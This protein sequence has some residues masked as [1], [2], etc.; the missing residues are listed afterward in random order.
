MKQQNSCFESKALA[1]TILEEVV[2]AIRFMS[3][4]RY[5]ALFK[6]NHTGFNVLFSRAAYV[7]SMRRVVD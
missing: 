6:V 5:N 2:V 3:L 7:F 1:K 4:R